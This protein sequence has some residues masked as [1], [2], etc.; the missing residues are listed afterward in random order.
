M[1]YNEIDSLHKVHWE[2]YLDRHH[3][4]NAEKFLD[5]FGDVAFLHIIS[6]IERT[7]ENTDIDVVNAI[8]FEDQDIVCQIFREDYSRLLELSME[9]Y[10]EQEAYEICTEIKELQKNISS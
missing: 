8:Y 4:P 6:I 10:I 2:K 9:W 5:E 1:E 3:H 7:H